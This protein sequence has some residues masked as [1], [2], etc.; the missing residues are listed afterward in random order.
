MLNLTIDPERCIGCGQCASDCPAQIITM[1][2][3]LPAIAA[4]LE[5]F[6]I[7]CR[8][9]VVICSEEALTISG[10]RPEAAMV[11]AEA[12][13]PRPEQLEALIKG[14]RSVRNYQ[15]RNVDPALIDRLLAVAA[16]APS[17]HNDRE[18]LFTVVDDKGILFDLREEA[19]AGLEK[20]L[21][22]NDLPAGMEMF[23]DIVAAWRSE[24]RDIL[25]RGAPHLLLVSAL[26]ESASPLQDC[27]IALTTFELYAVS[28]GL[29]T[30]WN[31]LAMLTISELVPSLQSRLGIPIDHQLGYVMGFGLPAVRYQ[32]CV[33]RGLPRVQR[34]R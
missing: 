3:S 16:H 2:N 34:V 6:C 26:A 5:Q 31:G 25:F 18:L 21:A 24:G 11:L 4:E 10:Y 23:A 32:R 17:G 14:R 7:D 20:R 22:A 29:G 19:I 13:L 8:H 33:D 12:P 30:L 1:E 15:Q 9:C 27:L 28:C